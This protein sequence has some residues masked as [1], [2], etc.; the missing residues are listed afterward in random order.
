MFLTSLKN[1]LTK[2]LLKQIFS[3]YFLTLFFHL[4][5]SL[6]TGTVALAFSAAGILLSGFVISHYKPRARY[7]AAWNVIVGFLT[8]AGI[9]AYAFIGCPGNEQ[10][11]IV[12][13]HDR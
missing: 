7:M 6:V 2:Y 1:S 10:S 5:H 13:I 4:L 3:T 11:V 8:V 9:L 12:N